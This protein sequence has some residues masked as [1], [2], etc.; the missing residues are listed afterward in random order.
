MSDAGIRY[1]THRVI[2]PKGALPQAAKVLDNSLPIHPTEI[3]IDVE[4]LNIDAASFTQMKQAAKGD[5]MGVAEIIMQTVRERGKQHNPVTGSGGML[6]GKVREIGSEYK[7]QCDI[8][9]GDS[10]ATLVS[11]T[12]TPLKLSSIDKVYMD[13]DQVEVKGYAILFES[14]VAVRLPDDFSRDAALAILDVAGAPAQTFRL[15]KPGMSVGIIGTGKSGL[16]CAAVARKILGKDGKIFGIARRQE[17]LDLIMQFGYVDTP[18]LADASN[19]VQVYEAVYKETN[20]KLLDVVLNTTNTPGTEM[21]TILSTR[22]GGTAYFFN[23]AT[24]FT[25][26]A[27]GAEGIGKDVTLLIGNGYVPDHAN[28]S[29]NVVREDKRL[30]DYFETK[31]GKK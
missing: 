16:L 11:L 23:M 13:R 12:L 25:A 7:G 26:A 27:L 6:T 10:I 18:V 1:G 22:D 4:M 21:S 17:S 29:L 8:K 15:V 30:K 2:E 31:Y 24:S 28:I 20:G 5:P 9:V 3:L 14:G 19:P